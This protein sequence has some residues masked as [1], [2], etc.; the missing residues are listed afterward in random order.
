M[1]VEAPCAEG[2]LRIVG[3]GAVAHA[4]SAS[5][6]AALKARRG[7]NKQQGVFL[8]KTARW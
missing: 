4:A 2:E 8:G 6:S 5:T 1:N 7:G 3:E